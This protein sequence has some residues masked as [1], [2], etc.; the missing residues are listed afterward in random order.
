MNFIRIKEVSQKIGVPASTI[1]LYLAQGKFPKSLKL[2]DKV[3]VWVE[4]DIDK[5]MQAQVD[6]AKGK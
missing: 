5:W 2:S 4:D 6:N 1:N 3:N